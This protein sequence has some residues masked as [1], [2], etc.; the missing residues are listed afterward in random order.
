M[1]FRVKHGFI[2]CSEPLIC[3]GSLRNSS[4][5]ADR[6]RATRDRLAD[7]VNVTCSPSVRY[8]GPRHC[9]T[10]VIILK[11]GKWQ[12]CKVAKPLKKLGAVNHIT[13]TALIHLAPGPIG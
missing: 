1:I 3:S 9:I 10:R 5:P 11:M 12:A 8:L 2:S 6:Q 4:Y 7:A 13:D